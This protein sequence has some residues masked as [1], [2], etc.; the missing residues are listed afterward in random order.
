MCLGLWKLSI[1]QTGLAADL[2][3]SVAPAAAT[4]FFKALAVAPSRAQHE[5]TALFDDCQLLGWQ[6]E[7][8]LRFRGIN[9][10]HIHCLALVE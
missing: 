8:N 1:V 6:L 4:S 5:S 7:Q 3:L 2:L 10:V 9:G